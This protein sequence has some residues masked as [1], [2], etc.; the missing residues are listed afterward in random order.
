MAKHW[1]DWMRDGRRDDVML[2][3]FVG[4]D[5]ALEHV[6]GTPKCGTTFAAFLEG[7]E[8]LSWE[9]KTTKSAYHFALLRSAIALGRAVL[10]TAMKMNTSEAA[11]EMLY[12]TEAYVS[13]PELVVLQAVQRLH[14]FSAP[15][16]FPREFQFQYQVAEVAFS[17]SEFG[18][19]AK[20]AEKILRRKAAFEHVV[21]ELRAHIIDRDDPIKRSIGE[22]LFFGLTLDQGE[23]DAIRVDEFP[24]DWEK[25]RTLKGKGKVLYDIIPT[26]KSL[27]LVSSTMKALLEK[28]GLSAEPIECKV[29]GKRV[30]WMKPKETFSV[31]S[32]NTLSPSE[33]RF[34]QVDAKKSKKVPPI[35][36]LR[37]NPQFVCVDTSFF[38]HWSVAGLKGLHGA[39]LPFGAPLK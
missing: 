9:K 26:S 32:K 15:P 35:F 37:E 5:A 14:F 31:L 33:L 34:L 11:P 19:V 28:L 36:F 29:N 27:F 21:R 8:K 30:F 12:T 6:P 25:T 38:K 20:S 3:A 7:I 2:G 23:D 17:P 39:V 16:T 4:D 1:D 13:W 18:R 22:R 24:R 10:P